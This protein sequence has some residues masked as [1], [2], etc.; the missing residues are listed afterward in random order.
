[1][2]LRN[3]LRKERD[4]AKAVST[5]VD[6]DGTDK[7]ESYREAM[8]NGTVGKNVGKA[9][10]FPWVREGFDTGLVGPTDCGK[11]SF[12]MQNVIAIAKGKCDIKLAPEWYDIPPTPVLLFSLEQSYEEINTYYGSVINNL[13]MLE[14]YAGSQITPKKII[15][16]IKE[17]KDI[18]TSTGMVVFVDNYSKLEDKAGVKAMKQFCEELDD[19]C[20]QSLKV[21]RPITPFK[22]YHAKP[23]WNPTK[24]L[25]PA[26]VRG[27]KKNV[28]FTNNFVYFTYCKHGSD[29]RV[30]GYMKLK[31][32]NKETLSILEYAGTE[33]DQF[34]YAGKGSKEE[35]GEAS[36]EQKSCDV[37]QTPG[38][39]SEYCLDEIMVLYDMV[40]AKEC[41]YAEIEAS[42]GIKKS[43][44]KKRIQRARKNTLT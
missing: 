19:L 1:M 15:D 3:E 40:Q 27:N 21:G 33:I 25:T 2:K 18:I 6:G 28:N 24:P 30:L 26:S 23:D 35:L 44:I 11:T 42:Y 16:I 20:S 34:R 37:K 17:K 22:V 4:A 7:I 13:P 38:R 8:R 5:F 12:V 32:G 9:L 31:H 39:K 14:I 29:K 36:T 41:T 10:G 43:M